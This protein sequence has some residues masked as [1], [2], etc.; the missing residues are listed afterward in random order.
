MHLRGFDFEARPRTA[1]YLGGPP[2]VE[3]RPGFA[4]CQASNGRPRQGM[5]YCSGVQLVKLYKEGDC[6]QAFVKL[7]HSSKSRGATKAGHSARTKVLGRDG[8]VAMGKIIRAIG[9]PALSLCRKSRVSPL[10]S[11]NDVLQSCRSLIFIPL[12]GPKSHGH[13]GR[14]LRLALATA[15]NARSG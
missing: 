5:G 6:W 15:A 1:L 3:S 2:R 7:S 11:V 14:A 8:K 12:R 4:V 10:L 13:S 9:V